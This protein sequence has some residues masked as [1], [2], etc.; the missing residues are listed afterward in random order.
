MAGIKFDITGN[1]QGILSSLKQTQAA[2]KDTAKAAEREGISI[3]Q[4][5]DRIKQAA[6]MTF[7][8]IGAKEF[9]QK[10]AQVRGEFQQLEIAFTTMLQS[11]EKANELMNQLVKTAAITPFDL[12]GVAEGAKQLLAYGTAVEEVNEMITRLGDIAAG[13]SI[14]LNDLVYLYGTTM[15]QGRMFTQDLR[16]FQGRGIP[17][18]DEIANIMGVTKDAVAELVSAGKITDQVF[19]QAILNM[20]NEGSKFGGLMEAQSKTITGQISNI[21]DALD[22]MFNDLG[23]QSEGVINDALSGVSYL[24]EHYEAVGKIILSVAASY[25]AYKA[26]LF[27]VIAAQKLAS[28]WGEVQAFFSLAKSV[29]SAKDAML[30]LNMAVKANPLGLLL[31]V[32]TALATS[33]ALFSSKEG[34][35]AEMTAKF[36]ERALSAINRVQSLTTTLNGLTVGTSTHKKVME[37]LNGILQEY[38]IEAIK[39]GDNIDSVNEKREKTIELIKREAIER[40]RANNLEMGM[41]EYNQKIADAQKKLYENLTGAQT[42]GLDMG[43]IGWISGNKELQDNAS[44]ISAIIAN[45]VERDIT[46]I[47]DKTGKEYEDGLKEIFA[48]IQERMRKIGISEET[49]ASEWLTDGLFN[50]QNLVQNYIESIKEAED[51]HTRY[52]EMVNKSADAE[53]D[54]ADGATTYAEKLS[55]IE[56]SLQGPNDSVRTLYNN[57]KTLMSQYTENTIGFTIRIGGEVPKWMETMDIPQLQQ[58]A[59]RF[60]ALGAANPNGVKIGDKYWSR[61][62]L[63]QRGADYAT[64]ADQKQTKKEQGERAA[65]EAAKEAEKHKKEREAEARRKVKE[66]EQLRKETEKYNELQRKQQQEQAR[67]IVD[68]ERSTVQAEI[69]ALEDGTKKVLMQ[70]ELDFDKRND[71]IERLYEDLKQ[72]KIDEARQL[73]EANPANK[74]K[75]FT[76]DEND[77]R[78]AYTEA[79]HENYVK[80]LE[81]NEAEYNRAKA[82]EAEKEIDAMNMY[83]QNYGTYQQQKLAIAQ[84]YA[85]RISKAQ[86]EGEILSLEKEQQEKIA[87]IDTNQIMMDIDWSAT[88]EG[89]GNVLSDIA[90]ETLKKVEDYM[91]S[92]EF[93]KLSPEAKKS[94]ADVRDRLIKENSHEASSPFNFKIWGQVAEDVKKYQ[95]SVIELRAAEEA[96]TTAV[97]ARK[98]AEETLKNATTDAA[99]ALAEDLVRTAKEE[100]N[101]TATEQQ[102]AQAKQK[103]AQN[104]LT[105]STTKA[106]Q[107]I[108]NF[109]D[110]MQ[111]ISNGSLYGFANGVTKLVTSFSG[112]SKGLGELGGKIG[113]IV[114]AILQI[115]D[116]LGDDPAQFIRDLL[117][118]IAKVIETVLSDLPN[119]IGNVIGG[120]GN[121]ITGVVSG[122]G[123]LFGADMTGIF[124]GGT[125]NFDAAVKRWGWLLDT[126]KDNLDYEKKVLEETYGS[127]SGEVL[128]RTVEQ[129]R[130]TQKAAAETYKAWASDGAGWF[131]HSNGYKENRNA[132]WRYLW[133][134]DQELAKRM[135]VSSHNM[136]GMNVLTNGDTDRL[137]DLSAEELKKLKYNNRQFWETLSDEARKYLDTIIEAEES[138]AEMERAAKEQITN[139]S[140]DTVVS[141]FKNALSNMDSEAKDFTDNFERYMTNAV[142]ESLMLAKYKKRLEEWYGS[143]ADAM[144]SD[145]ELSTA[146]RDA[147]YNQ[148]QAIVNDALAERDSLKEMFNWTGSN[149][150]EQESSSGGWQSMGQETAD[151]LNGRFTAL[152]ISG[153]AISSKM[154]VVITAVQTLQSVIAGRNDNAQEINEMRN[155]IMLIY[156]STSNIDERIKKYYEKW[157]SLFVSIARNVK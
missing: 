151:E 55:A 150:Y 122:I 105:D 157:D 126:W 47:A 127:K 25:G 37:E 54:A 128:T 86:T 120:V 114:G 101:R 59:K 94:Y 146:E 62:E 10:L 76:Y 52:T 148:Y 9:V 61:Q 84:D 111:E 22:M 8:G 118:R 77:P 123:K 80:M 24:V 12:K 100:E 49:I 74:G 11:E 95:Q 56:S 66:I 34:K 130:D 135:G 3:E 134:Y 137:F 35:A 5:F 133:D 36:G 129:L 83:L 16:Q 153:E 145:S 69:D 30:L 82:K 98:K 87:A 109:T 57:I 143:F 131:S 33:F 110:A 4:M 96:H 65:R 45:V 106:N 124:G 91:R 7:A 90:R 72:K 78:F 144:E 48:N 92:D 19:Q 99:K 115:I 32:V 113:G 29:T 6:S 155:L 26:A 117:D 102:A 138:I 125:E 15:T 79:E 58:L 71:E 41:T 142:L 23:K 63:L 156:N 149:P 17:I 28:V 147:L 21:E 85:K 27:A 39:E 104:D 89:V 140:F 119:L 75:A 18:A 13:M 1:N 141:D 132:N 53:R 81:A 44:A 93:K 112:V 43:L 103:Q 38:G 73:W 20:T 50:H 40:Q 14:P 64:A 88:F 154:D 108:K 60:S 121:I 51:A 152:Q 2:F 139:V 68:L 107:G 70:I 31:S 116:A 42:V 67:A 46:K 136:F 97:E